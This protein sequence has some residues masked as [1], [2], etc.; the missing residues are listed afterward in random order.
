MPK[1]VVAGCGEASFG[2]LDEIGDDQRPRVFEVSGSGVVVF[3]SRWYLREAWGGMMEMIERRR[4]DTGSIWT[5][6]RRGGEGAL[7][8]NSS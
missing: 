1:R 2:D 6:T 5:I 4:E 8:K 3:L 7:H